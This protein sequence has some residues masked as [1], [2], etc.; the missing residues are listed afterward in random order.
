MRKAHER[1]SQRTLQHQ[2]LPAGTRFGIDTEV[3]FR[4]L[5]GESTAAGGRP[6]R[7]STKD[8]FHDEAIG[9][10]LKTYGERPLEQYPARR[11]SDEDV[12]FWVD[13]KIME[14]ARQTAARHGVKP[15]RLLDAALT[16]YVKNHVP[17]QLLEFRR[18]VQQ[19]A[20]A[21]YASTRKRAQRVQRTRSR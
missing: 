19:Q 6:A 13:T 8:E 7:R 4:N 1:R 2:T 14:Q 16:L 18:T 21:L 9:W 10:F 3:W 17:P 11:A 20:L 12:T 5:I 15:A